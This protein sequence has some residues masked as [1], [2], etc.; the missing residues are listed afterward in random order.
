MA[1]PYPPSGKSSGAGLV[2]AKLVDDKLI[3]VSSGVAV[4]TLERSVGVT[5]DSSTTLEDMR[6]AEGSSL[7]LGWGSGNAPLLVSLT[8]PIS[9]C[10]HTVQYRLRLGRFVPWYLHVVM[11]YGVT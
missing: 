3:S 2:G 7:D 11:E 6:S 8:M 4:L 9:G 1:H 10:V 5:L